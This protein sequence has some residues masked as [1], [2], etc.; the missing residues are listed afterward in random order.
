[1]L[2]HFAINALSKPSGPVIANT[3]AIFY[4][5]QTDIDCTAVNIEYDT[6]KQRCRDLYN[7]CITKNEHRCNAPKV[8]CSEECRSIYYK[9]L[10]CQNNT[11]Q[12]PQLKDLNLLCSISND[13][14]HQNSTCLDLIINSSLNQMSSQYGYNSLC[15]LEILGN[16]TANCT[17]GCKNTLIAYKNDCCSINFALA[18]VTS[19]AN[20]AISIHTRRLWEH[21]QVENPYTCPKP[22]CPAS[23]P[24]PLGDSEDTPNRA[25][26]DHVNWLILF[27]TVLAIVA[28]A[29]VN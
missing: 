7:P 10:W 16:L 4:S 24:A 2:C 5:N 13:P 21:C 26:K 23:L 28:T 18:Q 22:S 8:F 1:M 19:D 29:V 9:M 3:R 17:E 25:P 27:A 12:L 20:N 6:E 15:F 14:R 11:N